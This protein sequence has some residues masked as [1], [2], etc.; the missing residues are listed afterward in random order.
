MSSGSD[1]HD[2]DSVKNRASN[3][4]MQRSLIYDRPLAEPRRHQHTAITTHIDDSRRM[5]QQAPSITSSEETTNIS[6]HTYTTNE[7]TTS[8]P[9]SAMPLERRSITS[10]SSASDRLSQFLPSIDEGRSGFNNHRKQ[11]NSYY[12][13]KLND[14][15]YGGSSNTMTSL[16]SH[17]P[18]LAAASDSSSVDSTM[19]PMS[20]HG[21]DSS[22]S[23]VDYEYEND[24]DNDISISFRSTQSMPPLAPSSQSPGRSYSAGSTRR[25]PYQA[26]TAKQQQQQPQFIRSSSASYASLPSLPSPSSQLK[27][28]RSSMRRMSRRQSYPP[29]TQ[30]YTKTTKPNTPSSSEVD[31]IKKMNRRQCMANFLNS[32]VCMQLIVLLV[33]AILVLWS[34]SQAALA[35]DT[36]L[37]LRETESVSLLKLHRLESHSMHVHELMRSRLLRENGKMKD[38]DDIEDLLNGEDPEEA[39]DSKDDPL[40][41]QYQQL[42]Q[43][44]SDLRNHAAVTTLQSN[45]Q[46]TA[47]DKMIDLYGEGP[48]KVVV[49]LDFG[50]DS[51]RRNSH[52]LAKGSYISIVL[53]PDTPHAAWTWLDQI[54][55][56]VWDG[57]SVGWDPTSTFL[58]F[59][60]TK[61]DPL[62]RGHLEFVEGHPSQ[63]QSNPDM[64][65][66]AWTIGLRETLGDDQKS[67]R[68]EMFINLANN[69]NKRKHETCVG[70]IFDG[71]DALQRL[72]EGTEVTEYGDA[73]T[74]VS[75]KSVSAMHMTHQ[76]FGQIF[77]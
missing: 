25:R 15:Y 68:L 72:L 50:D 28:E 75:V 5:Q 38:T 67:S 30:V 47:I 51:N 24:Y 65:H 43:M 63:E 64:H 9:N 2:R 61:E 26:L 10:S 69:Q 21:S 53:W 66:G 76:E 29:I 40:M 59:K 77:R 55:R 27:I 56:N 35:T 41:D 46:E 32:G 20:T 3:D 48:V 6:N 71:F 74:K 22:D 34:R 52:E 13:Q 73:V 70:K 1:S 11:G 31:T 42:S 17:V 62:D 18:S 16:A 45:I 39:V 54:V 37:H 7:S 8:P 19:D 58:Q 23:S 49:E 44:A 12:E 33:I 57:S 60:P 4:N 14:S 36:L